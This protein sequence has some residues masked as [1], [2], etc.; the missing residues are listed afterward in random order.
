MLAPIPD[1]G[2]GVNDLFVSQAGQFNLGFLGLGAKE[3]LDFSIPAGKSATFR[4]RIV[5]L[6]AEPKPEAIEAEYKRFTAGS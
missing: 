4:H 5:I 6:N 2:L 3:T 1:D